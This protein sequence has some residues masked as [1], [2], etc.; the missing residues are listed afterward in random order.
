MKQELHVIA[1]I[2]TDF[3]TKFGLPRQGSF[4]GSL[5]GKIVF[6]KEYRKAAALKGMEEY[7]HLWLIWGFSEAVREKWVPTVKPP[8]L[9]GKIRKG[10]FATRSPYRPNPIGLTCV[11]IEKIETDTPEGPVIWVSGIDMMS[12]SPIY[13]I[14]PYLP[15]SDS[16]P[17]ALSG[18]GGK[19]KDRVLQV[20]FPEEL[21]DLV[22]EDKRDGAI[23]ML[24]QDP[25]TPYHNHREQIF[26]IAYSGVDIH[27][28]VEEDV[29]TVCRVEELEDDPEFLRQRK[30]E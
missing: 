28:T 24:M 5:K 29:L 4:G 22:P 9:G 3:P 7:S 19:E 16:Y 8:R 2:E 13:D 23:Q 25:R 12:G 30:P 14:K 1:N 10:V 6:T 17:D 21:L 18:F 11:K 26:K 15:C 27:F 20:V